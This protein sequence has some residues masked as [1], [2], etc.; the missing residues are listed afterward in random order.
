[1]YK[2][3]YLMETVENNKRV[4]NL[5]YKIFIHKRDANSFIERIQKR[6]VSVKYIDQVTASV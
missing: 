4:Y 6:F 5:V 1:M 3:D 2:V